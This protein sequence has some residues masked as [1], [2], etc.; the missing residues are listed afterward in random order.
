MTFKM[1]RNG[2]L[3]LRIR[4]QKVQLAGP[5]QGS[6][7]VTLGFHK[8]GADNLCAST[9]ASFRKTRGRVLIGR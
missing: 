1:R 2:S 3:S 6:V 9:M 8:A 5:Q 7:Q 4:G